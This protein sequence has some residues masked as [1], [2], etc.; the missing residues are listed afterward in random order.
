MRGK[1]TYDFVMYRHSQLWPLIRDLQANGWRVTIICAEDR[2]APD[3]KQSP[4]TYCCQVGNDGWGCGGSRIGDTP[5]ECVVRA[6]TDLV[7]V[8]EA[9]NGKEADDA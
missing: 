4:G 1:V 3:R 6:V 9:T 5:W 7:N 2:H 8:A